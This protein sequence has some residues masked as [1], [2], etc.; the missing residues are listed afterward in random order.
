MQTRKLEKLGLELPL[1]GF[2]CMRLPVKA[3]KTID[4]VTATAMVDYALQNG[5]NYFD[6]ALMYHNGLSEGFIGETLKKYPRESYMLTTKLHASYLKTKEDVE[7]IFEE[8]LARCRVEYFDFYLI[9]DVERTKFDLLREFDV[10]DF[11]KQKQSEGKIRHLGC[12]SH[13][14]HEYIAKF[15]DMYDFDIVQLQI[16]YVDWNLRN[17]E[18]CYQLLEERGIPCIVM[19][20]IKGGTLAD[21]PDGVSHIFKAN[22]PD[23][24][25]ASYA[26]RWVASLPNVKMVLS[27][28]STM[29]QLVENTK[30]LSGFTP[31]SDLEQ[32]A[33]MAAAAVFESG[34]QIAC[35]GCKYCSE[36]PVGVNIPGIFSLYNRQAIFGGREHFRIKQHYGSLFAENEKGS[37][38]IDCKRCVEVCPQ[39][40]DIP[41]ELKTAHNVLEEILKK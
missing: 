27:G 40:I 22:N 16:N 8:Q 14:D 1:L 13:E 29:E 6:T 35:T 10:Y 17:A 23:A 36:C 24:T 30:V 38:C 7:R 39:H 26:L 19:E 15:L 21:V 32:Q 25:P 5:I 34:K 41:A 18:K 11:L 33:I 20:P 28:M 12:S 3:D 4:T 2:G 31:L 37:A 9:H